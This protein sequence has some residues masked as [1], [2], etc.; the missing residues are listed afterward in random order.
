MDVDIAKAVKKATGANSVKE[1]EVIQSLW[2]GY[3]QIVRLELDNGQMDNVILKH[4][5]LSTEANHPRGWNTSNSHQRKVKSY[6]VETHWYAYWHKEAV[7]YRI[8]KSILTQSFE[9]SHVI[10]M[11]DLDLSGFPVRKNGLNFKEVKVCLQWL[12]QFH[13]THLNLNPTGLWTEGTYWHLATRSD[14]LQAMADSPLKKQA[15]RIS[16]E[17]NQGNFSTILHGDAK[18]ANFCF[19]TDG[20]S[21]A[22]VDFQYVGGGCGM[23]DVAYFLGSCIT[24][25]QCELWETELLDYYFNELAK[26]NSSKQVDFSA[27]EK[28]WRRLYYFAWADFERFLLGWMPTHQKLTGFSKRIVDKVV[29]SLEG[30]SIRFSGKENHS[31]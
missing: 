4:I 21:V 12:A 17:L 25:E 30:P 29:L 23:K 24:E 15:Q 11:E 22:A 20:N 7:P 18:L 16:D 31:G 2:S 3:G 5:D 1:L 13:G 27:L 8:P 19:S 9:N 14:E 10:V 26:Y 6:E 28:E